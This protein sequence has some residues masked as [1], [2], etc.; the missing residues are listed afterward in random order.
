MLEKIVAA[1]KN[2]VAK[3]ARSIET[4]VK[5]VVQP[6]RDRGN[7]LVGA[8]H[9]AVRPR[10]EL[11]A[12]NALLRQQLIVVRRQIKRPILNATGRIIMVLLARLHKAWRD[13]LHL[14]KP[15]TLLR[16]HRDMFKLIWRR[17]SRFRGAQPRRLS[18][19]TIELITTMVRDNA[20]WGA[21]RIR[22]ELLKLGIRVSKRTI[23]KY[24]KRA[25]PPQ[26]RGQTWKTFLENHAYDIWACDFLQLHDV[27]FQPIFAF[28][29]VKHG[30]REVAHVGVTRTPSDQWAAQQLRE[31]TPFG[32]GTRFLIRDNDGTFGR[33]LRRGRRRIRHRSGPDPVSVSQSESHLRAISR[34]R[35]PRVP[36][37]RRHPERGAP[38]SCARRVC[39]H[40]LQQ[41]TTPPEV[42]ATDSRGCWR[43]PPRREERRGG[44]P[45]GSRRPPPRLS[46]GR[47][48]RG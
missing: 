14:V 27:L 41:G 15:D 30:T 42:G 3:W 4:A 9:D 16:W 39:I 12:E 47:M 45:A 37:P 6:G 40:V 13:A 19:D 23:Q 2:V 33:I 24:M 5:R 44:R 31:A 1:V 35:A 29:I 26:E 7:V 8:A 10:S 25:L 21:E 46:E 17:K 20:T 18:R 34:K 48:T 22:G 36:R 38:S 28:S 43:G 32:E 11:I